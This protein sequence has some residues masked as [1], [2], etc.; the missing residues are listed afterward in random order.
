MKVRRSNQ[1]KPKKNKLRKTIQR[2]F[3]AKNRLANKVPRARTLMLMVENEIM[4]NKNINEQLPA[5]VIDDSD[6]PKSNT[7][8][9]ET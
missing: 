3:K 7:P 2:S 1:E 5:R 4:Y 6:P 8:E 9:S